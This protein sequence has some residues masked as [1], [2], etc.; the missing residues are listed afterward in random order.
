MV[1]NSVILEKFSSL[2]SV[3][4]WIDISLGVASSFWLGATC[5]LNDR[6]FYWI[7]RDI[8]MNYT[9]WGDGEPSNLGGIEECME[10]WAFD[11]GNYKWNDAP[12]LYIKFFICETV[13]I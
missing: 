10:M 8:P 7:G 3:Q 13:W 1:S 2:T 5:Q 12:C 4:N 6:T 9:N 11:N